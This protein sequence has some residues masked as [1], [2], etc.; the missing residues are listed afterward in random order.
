MILLEVVGLELEASPETTSINS[1]LTCILEKV[2]P[3]WKYPMNFTC[4]PEK[5][6]LTPLTWIYHVTLKISFHL[7]TYVSNIIS[8]DWKAKRHSCISSDSSFIYLFVLYECKYLIEINYNNSG[9]FR[10]LDSLP[11]SLQEW[12]CTNSRY[13]THATL[14]EGI[15]LELYIS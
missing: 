11:W 6:I 15:I 12:F 4:S 5:A 3:F 9:L 8:S 14:T 13:V 7:H 1:G 10:F 2:E